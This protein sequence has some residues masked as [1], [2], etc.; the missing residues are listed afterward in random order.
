M[1]EEHVREQLP[2]YALGVLEE[3]ERAAVAQHLAQCG[4]CQADLAVYQATTADLTAAVRQV[5]PPTRL[6]ARLLD[7]LAGAPVQ[8]PAATPARRATRSGSWWES[9]RRWLAGPVWRPLGLA[10]MLIIALGLLVSPRQADAPGVEAL[11]LAGTE[12]VPEAYA[13]VV[14]GSH[15]DRTIGTLV[16]DNLPPLGPDEQYQLWLIKDGRIS[17]G[18]FDVGEDGYGSM[19]I[20]APQDLDTYEFG[21]TVE[22]TGGSPGP[23]GEKVLGSE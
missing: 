12:A 4:P 21:V 18:V 20:R 13:I 9:A 11:P 16:V 17:G 6:K 22:P 5:D 10:L 7:S 19:T 3:E 1:R 14:L 2:A 15:Y 23:T 8:S